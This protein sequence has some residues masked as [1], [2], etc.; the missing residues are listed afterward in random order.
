MPES[1]TGPLSLL[2]FWTALVLFIGYKWGRKLGRNDYLPRLM[3]K[4]F[5]VSGYHS[6]GVANQL[7]TIARNIGKQYKKRDHLIRLR[8]APEEVD[9][10]LDV[11]L[12][13][14]FVAVINE[15]EQLW[16]LRHEAEA[17]AKLMGHGQMVD[18]IHEKGIPQPEPVQT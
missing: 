1:I 13:K 4:H 16:L 10:M 11:D 7:M 6:E 17:T 15:I 18:E 2:I 12:N 9:L 5:L 3:K 14:L 8:K